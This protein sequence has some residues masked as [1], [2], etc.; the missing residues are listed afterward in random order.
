[1][2]SNY[3]PPYESTVTKKLKNLGMSS[4]GKCNMDEFAMG[5]SGEN[6]QVKNTKNPH[7]T[8]RIPG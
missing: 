8:N 4:L 1:M 6:S 2:L 7:G 3:I 5:S